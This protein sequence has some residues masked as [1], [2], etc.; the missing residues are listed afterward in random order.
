MGNPA[1]YGPPPDKP[2]PW[3]WCAKRLVGQCMGTSSCGMTLGPVSAC[4]HP[5][6]PQ[7]GQCSSQ[8]SRTQIQSTAGK[9]GSWFEPGCWDRPAGTRPR[10]SIVRIPT[11]QTCPHWKTRSR[12]SEAGVL[13]VELLRQQGAEGLEWGCVE[14]T[15][16]LNLAEVF[17]P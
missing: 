12:K 7:Q 5:G 6:H 16:W 3:M 11:P 10:E 2:A 15:Q 8:N 1:G 13:E 4:S 9:V 14:K 17:Q